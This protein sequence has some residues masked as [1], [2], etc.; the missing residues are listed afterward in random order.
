MYSLKFEIL[1]FIYSYE[2]IAIEED[3]Y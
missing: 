3:L 2:K 1:I